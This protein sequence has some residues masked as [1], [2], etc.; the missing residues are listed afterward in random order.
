MSQ[1]Q[2]AIAG[3]ATVAFREC[4][5]CHRQV[6]GEHSHIYHETN[7]D[8]TQG[9]LRVGC[10]ECVPMPSVQPDIPAN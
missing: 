4:E 7:S 9:P 5:S 6:C 8:G 1:Q 10:Y 2:C 3:C